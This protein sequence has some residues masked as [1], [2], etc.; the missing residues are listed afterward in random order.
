MI[1]LLPPEYLENRRLGQNK[2]RILIISSGIIILFLI[3]GGIYLN[4]VFNITEMESK[5]D[6]ARKK[7]V[8]VNQQVADIKGIKADNKN[9]EKQLATNQIQGPKVAITPALQE[10]KLV[11]TEVSWLEKLT[12]Y[13]QHLFKLQGYALTR[14]EFGQVVAKLKQSAYFSWITIDFVRQKKLRLQGY[15]PAEVIYYQLN[16]EINK[17]GNNHAVVD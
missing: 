4:L 10:L 7:L 13:R 16:G 17:V 6:I 2:L 5:L 8:Q 12:F 14:E 9:L 15:Q 11:V 3:V 1:N